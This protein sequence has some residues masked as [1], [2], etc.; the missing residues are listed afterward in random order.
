MQD[1]IVIVGAARTPMGGFQGSL[2]DLPAADLGATAIK[3]A[4]ERSG[5]AA[6]DVQEVIDIMGRPED[7][8]GE[9]EQERSY[10]QSAAGRRTKRRLYRD[11]DKGLIAGVC[12][13]TSVA[14]AEPRYVGPGG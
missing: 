2:S 7:Y 10:A 14:E 8:L 1:P 13:G 4:V 3:A 6:E 12:T 9:E 5:L 11:D